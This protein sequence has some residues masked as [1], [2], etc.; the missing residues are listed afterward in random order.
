[1]TKF[2]RNTD[3]WIDDRISNREPLMWNEFIIFMKEL[4]AD[5]KKLKL[6]SLKKYIKEV[7]ERYLAIKNRNKS[8]EWS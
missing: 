6:Y 2:D 4:G 5:K 1:M 3:N 8:Q 7:K